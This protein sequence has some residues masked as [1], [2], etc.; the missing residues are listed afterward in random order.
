MNQQ[1]NF[2]LK[3]LSIIGKLHGSRS[4]MSAKKTSG[5]NRQISSS[6]DLP[7]CSAWSY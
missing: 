2:H 1:C 5:K 7:V 6:A 3:I 4:W